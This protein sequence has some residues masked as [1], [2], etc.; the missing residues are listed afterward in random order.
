[1]TI[2]DSTPEEAIKAVIVDLPKLA[3]EAEVPVEVV[4]QHLKQQLTITSREEAV[5]AAYDK[6][7]PDQK[8]V[9]LHN[10]I[11]SGSIPTLP[12]GQPN[13]YFPTNRSQRRMRDKNLRR[14]RLKTS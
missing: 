1:V 14:G 3:D 2:E 4:D 10:M 7:S 9:L 5:R 13:P 12:N 8:K 6:L 11:V